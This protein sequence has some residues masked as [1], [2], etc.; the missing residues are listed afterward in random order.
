MF[1]AL[2]EFQIAAQLW[3]AVRQHV[4]TA[5]DWEPDNSQEQCCWILC[6]RLL[7]A[8]HSIGQNVIDEVIDQWRAQ[9]T[10]CV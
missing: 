8:W 7:S 9:L 3:A 6:Q 5:I 1:S 2:E 4:L 10:A